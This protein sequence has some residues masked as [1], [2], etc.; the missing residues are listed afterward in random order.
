[1]TNRIPIARHTGP[2]TVAKN[3]V[4]WLD[5][6]ASTDPDGNRIARAHWLITD[7]TGAVVFDLT[8]V[9][10]RAPFAWPGAATLTVKLTVT[11]DHGATSKA[12]ATT[13]AVAPTVPVPTPTPTPTPTPVPVPPP[14]GGRALLGGW[15]I[16]EEFAQG[17]IAI[18]F[19]RMKLWM[20]GHA[21]RQELLEYDLPPMGTGSDIAAWPRV[22][23]ISRKPPFWQGGY[24]NGLIFWRGKVWV[25]DRVFYDI[26]PPQTMTLTAV[27]GETIAIAAPRQ[28]FSGFVKR[29]PGL[30]PLIG[31]GGYESGQGSSSG[32]SLCTLDGQV[33]F[34][35]YWPGDPGPVDANGVPANWNAGRAPRAPN[36]STASDTWVAWNPRVIGGELQGRWASDCVYGGGLVL[37]EGITYWAYQGTGDLDYARQ[38]PTFAA[39]GMERTSEYRYDPSTYAFKGYWPRPDLVDGP[40]LGQELGPDGRVYLAHGNQWQSGAYQVDVALK[41]F[42]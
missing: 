11:D 15:R 42:G 2:Y 6:S 1:M 30:D 8:D 5:A 38:R 12:V 35:H 13:I 14:A 17:C 21:Q 32:P 41:V 29:G 25:S 39:Q 27:D 34:R 20:V 28:V 37:P 24:G 26:T 23:P 16:T 40:V 7:A 36:Y 9:Q 33:M 3:D 31:C 10:L 22:D 19:S 4:L 18:D